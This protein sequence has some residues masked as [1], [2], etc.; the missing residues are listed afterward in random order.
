M[1]GSVVTVRTR[2]NRLLAIVGTLLACA[3]SSIAAPTP[4]A[5]ALEQPESSTT[6]TIDVSSVS[7]W[8]PAEGVWVA[9]LRIAGAPADA[10]ITY[11]I[12]QPPSG[13]EQAVRVALARERDGD[14]EESVMR[15]AVEQQLAPLTDPSGTTR[16]EIPIREA[17][18]GQRD[19]IRIPNPGVYPVVITVDAG[20]GT[21]LGTTTLHLNRLPTDDRSPFRLGILVQPSAHGGFDVEGNLDITD[22]LRSSVRA[23]VDLVD[24]AALLPARLAVSPEAV[25]AL[26]K[27]PLPG[28]RELID[29]L[30]DGLGDTTVQRVPWADLHLEGWATSGRTDDV[31]G[32]LIDGQQALFARLQQP[33]DV[34]LWPVDSSIGPASVSLL[35]RLGIDVL[36]VEADQLG[37]EQGPPSESGATRPSR[38][39]GSDASIP[40]VTLDPQAQA[41]LETSSDDPELTASQLLALMFGSWLADEHER[42]SVIRTDEST[43]LRVAEAL[44]DLI[45]A[46]SS[47]EDRPA[48]TV[49]DPAEVGSLAPISQRQ[50]GRDLVWE[51]TLLA[52]EITPNVQGVAERLSIARPLVDDYAAIMPADDPIAAREAVVIQRSLDRSVSPGQQEELLDAS[53][54]RMETD[55]DKISASEPRTLRVTARR[56][57]IPLRFTNDTGRPIR[58]RLRLESPRLD[59]VDGNLQELTLQPGLNRL[60]VDVEVRASGQFTMQADLIAPNSDRVLA[61]TR[62]QVRSTTFSGVGLLLSGG[63]LLFLVVWW[64]RTLRRRPDATGT[65]TVDATER[66]ATSN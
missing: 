56:T 6:V 28:D 65:D 40:A 1:D 23:A 52:P 12:R 3:L 18:T 22:E 20:D 19:R 47:N 7:A 31:Q 33:A 51:R 27:S 14:V 24:A 32:S 21:A 44:F 50:G 45:R 63:A 43:D 62:Q 49:V 57:P 61:S 4:G 38:V 34:R 29:R 13:T 58:A 66:N 25:V 39:V 15:S 42:G 48:I 37:D 53:I 35:D 16:L 46:G 36:I 26:T 30:R 2:A 10:T 8:V 5:A 17:G 59:F 41:L 55:L 9:E 64:S 54:S 60:D 11:S